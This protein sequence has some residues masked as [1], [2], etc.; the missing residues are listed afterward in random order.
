MRGR[1]HGEAVTDEVGALAFTR[2]CPPHQSPAATA[3][4]HRGSLGSAVHPMPSPGGRWIRSEA[5]Q[6][7]EGRGAAAVLLKLRSYLQV[8]PGPHQSRLRRA[9]FPQG[10]PLAHCG[11]VHP[12]GPAG[13]LPLTRGALEMR[14]PK[15]P[16]V[17]GRCRAKRG[18]EVPESFL[19]PPAPAGRGGGP[20]RSGR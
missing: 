1:C 10:K 13:Q 4:P 3:S 12:S 8:L 7:D 14:T 15:P 19:T 11:G 17:K 18:G 6:T 20:V 5:E 9:S 16:L 2:R